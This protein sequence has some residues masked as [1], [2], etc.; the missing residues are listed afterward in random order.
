[1]A[2]E[3]HTVLR[4]PMTDTSF[5][6]NVDLDELSIEFLQVSILEAALAYVDAR[7]PQRTACE[8]ALKDAVRALRRAVATRSHASAS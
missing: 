4:A 1:M 8:I 2:L 3:E 5:I 6:H 7:G